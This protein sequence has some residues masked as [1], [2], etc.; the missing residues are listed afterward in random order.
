MIMCIFLHFGICFVLSP[1]NMQPTIWNY[2]IRKGSSC[3]KFVEPRKCFTKIVL[4]Y[5]PILLHWYSKDTLLY[6]KNEFTWHDM[7]MWPTLL[8]GIIG[9]SQLRTATPHFLLSHPPKKYLAL[10]TRFMFKV[11]GMKS[12]TTTNF[13]E[14]WRWGTDSNYPL[15]GV[16]LWWI[17]GWYYCR[18]RSKS[19]LKEGQVSATNC[20]CS[21]SGTFRKKIQ[22]MKY[23]SWPEV[24]VVKWKFV[25]KEYKGLTFKWFWEETG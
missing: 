8:L 13:T 11:G 12:Q 24:R 15:G 5:F 2:L 25:R 6:S 23:L 18:L 17:Y 3:I 22:Q 21:C 16:G 9:S 7:R 1:F 14:W 4:L 20:Q 10:Y 19:L